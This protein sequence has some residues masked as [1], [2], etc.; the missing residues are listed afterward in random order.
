MVEF[1]VRLSADGVPMVFHDDRLERTSTGGGA[2]GA[3]DLTQL[4]Q[5]DAG[6]WFGP[7]FAGETIP[8]LAEALT[9]CAGLGIAVNIEIKP[10]SG[11]ERETAQA[12]LRV[13]RQVWPVDLPP[14]LISSF[15]KIALTVAFQSAPDWPRGLLVEDLPPDWRQATLD[16]GCTAIHA[17]ASCL[18]ADKVAE[19]RAA[20]L[21][22]LAYTVNDSH[23]A[24]AL[25]QIGVASVFS[26]FPDIV[27]N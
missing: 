15:H 25:W 5:L 3:C 2:V 20:G 13:A 12:A 10:D 27:T 26:D 19:I 1:D 9:C 21:N 23:L 8:T 16:L 24:S 7:A 17:A 14:P 22:V 18:N 6:T 4:K 11:H